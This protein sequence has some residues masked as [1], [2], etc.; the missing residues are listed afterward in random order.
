MAT[1]IS[2]I[3]G[4]QNLPNLVEFDASDNYLESIDLSGLT[5]LEY[6]RL[7]DCSFPDGGNSLTSVDVT[8]CT[9]LEYLDINDSD[10]SAGLPVLSSCTSL[11][12]FDADDCGIEGSL[13]LSN[14]PALK[15]FDLSG[16]EGIT[17]VIISS[18]Q[19]IGE[20]IDRYE[21]NRLTFEGCS[22]TQTSVD[23]ILQQLASGS[24]SDSYVNL[25]DDGQDTM[26]RPSIVGVEAIRTL[27][28]RLWTW[29]TVNY[30]NSLDI[31]ITH[32]TELDAAN[33][34]GNPLSDHGFFLIGE[35]LEVGTNIYA[36]SNLLIAKEDGWFGYPTNSTLYLVSGGNGLIVS[37]SVLS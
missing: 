23:N 31:T 4:L 16:N 19:P 1:S 28:S 27:Y 18:T 6:V 11:E 20:Y 15:G 26:A 34:I 29:D 25:S 33:D 17:E 2:A 36:D 22:L 7:E 9:S 13:D 32:E 37:S 3:T 30:A 21:G 14:L 10:F 12:Y 35:T 8:G 5:N 24:I